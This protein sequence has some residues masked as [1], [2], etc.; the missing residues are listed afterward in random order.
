MGGEVASCSVEYQLALQGVKATVIEGRGIGSQTSGFSAGG[1]N[2]LQGS[3]IPGPL[4]P[5]AMESYQMHRALYD[6]LMTENGI[7]YG[8]RTVSHLKVGFDEESLP[9]LQETVDI[10]AGSDGFEANWLEPEDLINLEPRLGPGVIRGANTRGNASLDSY[11][12]TLAL[13]QGVERLGAKV[14]AGT[15]RGLKQSNGRVT[16]VVL[17]DSQIA[18]GQVVLAMGPWPRKAESWLDLYLLVDPL[19]GEILRVQLPGGSLRQDLTG[20]GASFYVKPNGL[21]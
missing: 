6:A 13:A 8:W 5:L 2:P 21:V 7:D 14:C 16:G 3:G 1:L 9:E 18:C 15:V 4:G 20:G 12:Y 11:R 17:E 19:K 10:F